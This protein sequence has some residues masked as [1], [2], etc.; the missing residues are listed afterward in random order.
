MSKNQILLLHSF[1][2]LIPSATF[3]Q[4]RLNFKNILNMAKS[5]QI[6][7]ELNGNQI[8]EGNNELPEVAIM[9]QFAF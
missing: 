7:F 5:K 8:L 3:S 6:T 9:A 2:S 4:L 1:L